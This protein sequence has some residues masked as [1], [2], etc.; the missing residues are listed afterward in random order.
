MNRISPLTFR[1]AEEKTFPHPV[2]PVNPVRNSPSYLPCLSEY[3]SIPSE[4]FY[5]DGKRVLVQ[6]RRPRS[7]SISMYA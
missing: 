1:G 4:I 5:W 3:L 7:S 6:A 2:N